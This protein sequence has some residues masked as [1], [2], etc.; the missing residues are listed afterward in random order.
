MFRFFKYFIEVVEMMF[1]SYGENMYSLDPYIFIYMDDYL[2]NKVNNQI[3]KL[4]YI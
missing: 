3:R 1:L 4:Q 2:D